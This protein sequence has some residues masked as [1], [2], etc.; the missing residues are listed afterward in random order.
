MDGVCTIGVVDEAYYR[1]QNEWFKSAYC[2]RQNFGFYPLV[3]YLC[4]L[5][6][7]E[8]RARCHA[9]IAH[10]SGGAKVRVHLLGERLDVYLIVVD[11]WTIGE[12]ELPW[13]SLV[14]KL[15]DLCAL[16]L[17]SLQRLLHRG[18]GKRV[19]VKI[20]VCWAVPVLGSGELDCQCRNGTECGCDRRHCTCQL[21]G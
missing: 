16:Q 5:A 14:S 17:H 11:R 20:V 19:L 2:L 15:R 4:S 10:Q 1:L 3:S 8:S 9:I 6:H 12:G 7:H 18:D 13:I 21:L